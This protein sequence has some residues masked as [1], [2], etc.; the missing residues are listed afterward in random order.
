LSTSAPGIRQI[1]AQENSLPVAAR[2]KS[3]P[4][5]PSRE[6]IA[7]PTPLVLKEGHIA[8]TGSLVD[9]LRSKAPYIQ[10]YLAKVSAKVVWPVFIFKIS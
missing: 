2:L 5:F 6:A 10:E 3:V 4:A 9:L 7:N 8:F 1:H